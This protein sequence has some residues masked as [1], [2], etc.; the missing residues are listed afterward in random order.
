MRNI[1]PAFQAK[2]DAGA[3]T[4]C[5][6]WIL[7]RRDGVVQ[8]FTDHDQT[9]IVNGVSCRADTGFTGSEAVARLGLSVDGVEVSGALSDDSLNESALAAGHYD[10]A[11]VDMYIVDWSEPALNVLMTRGHIGEV[12]RE[13]AAFAA[14]LRGLADT[15]AHE[16]GRL[17]TAACSADLGDTRCKIDLDDPLYRGEG[18]IVAPRGV[19]AFTVSGLDDFDVGWFTAGRLTFTSGANGGS[20]M[21]V[22][23]HYIASD[24]VVI[25]LWQAMAE[26]IAPEDTFIVTAGCDKRFATCRDRFNNALNFRG[27]PHIPGND[28]IVRYAIDGEPG[29]DGKSLS[30]D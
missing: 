21:E 4:L 22:K 24:N 14:E 2:L 9:V 15:L 20:A 28:F 17:Y 29:H 18:S 26:P 5:R 7:T 8:G 10:A 1:S 23:R 12:R 11:Q 25:E 30:G 27:F 3:T 16:T 6:C 13:G 19:S